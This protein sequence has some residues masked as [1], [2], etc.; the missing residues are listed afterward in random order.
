MYLKSLEIINYRLFYEKHYFDFSSYEDNS[1][2]IIFGRDGSGK[3]SLIDAI[4][5]C[6]Y[7]IDM[8]EGGSEPIYNDIIAEETPIGNEFN[9]TVVLLFI[10][11]QNQEILITRRICFHKGNEIITKTTDFDI[12]LNDMPI[13]CEDLFIKKH[14]SK[15]LFELM[16]INDINVLSDDDFYIKIK[17][18]LYQYFQLDIILN[19]SNHL[20]KSHSKL[21]K[22]Y[23]E[24]NHISNVRHNE[25]VNDY[26][27]TRSKI[28]NVSQDI[29]EKERLIKEYQFISVSKDLFIKKEF[30]LNK[31]D[32]LTE[33]FVN[34]KLNY[35]QLVLNSYP[36]T[37]LFND[38]QSNVEGF[39][40][41]F[42]S[43]E[44][45]KTSFAEDIFKLKH[46]LKVLKDINVNIAKSVKSI[47]HFEK[48]IYEI[49]VEIF[50]INDL[51][52]VE[53]PK[54]NKINSLEKELNYLILS[55]DSL[56][57]K[58]ES[59]KHEISDLERQMKTTKSKSF[60]IQ[61]KDE[62]YENAISDI[63]KLHDQLF[64]SILNEISDSVNKIF[65][66]N[67][68]M[69]NKYSNINLDDNLEVE[70]IKNS[71]KSIEFFDLSRSEQYII[72]LSIA[73]SIQCIINQNVFL[74]VD[75]QF[76]NFDKKHWI[77]FLSLLNDNN[78]QCILL[79]NEFN[80]ER[81]VK[82]NLINNIAN[83][84]ELINSNDKIKVVKHEN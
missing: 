69:S 84:Y 30:L 28:K 72:Y 45:L 11:N 82:L 83:E 64:K 50:S 47:S 74:I 29:Y 46:D 13:M 37:V 40:T 71:G 41:L 60:E 15:N 18:I 6:L 33:R 80:H 73:L 78:Q 65:I 5:W 38:L 4:Y 59:L 23:N 19:A 43:H 35:Y 70:I 14:C 21:L 27:K 75:T 57:Y 53:E 61:E 2:N 31:L 12:Y 10:D 32:N 54:I 48:E 1:L 17:S 24:F 52:H 16:Y 77:N 55:R 79:F 7:G 51:L 34:E 3:S 67:F 26:E 39:K 22:E 66:Q 20:K 9:V 36:M 58:E 62:F 44:N 63:N 42:N 56:K 49:E 68:G 25:L 76:L 81:S 8:R